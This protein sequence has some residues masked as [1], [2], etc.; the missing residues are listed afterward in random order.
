MAIEI[1]MPKLGLTME[2]ALIIQWLVDDDATVEADQPILLIETDKTETEVGAPGSG[3]LHQIGEPG[4]VFPCG[5][6]IGLL[7][8]E[9][10]T[11]PEPAPTAAPAPVVSTAAV[12][13]ARRRPDSGCGD[14]A[15]DPGGRTALRLTERA[16]D[17]RRPRGGAAHRAR[18]GA[19]RSHRLRRR[20]CGP[21][22]HCPGRAGGQR[23]RGRIGRRAHARRPARHRSRDRAR[24]PGGA[25]RHPGRGRDARSPA[26]RPARATDG[27]RGERDRRR[28]RPPRRQNRR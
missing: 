23:V 6:L 7:L 11:P 13:P 8:A 20:R 10:E 26:P 24:R 19:R 3:R 17:R 27:P 22:R 28:R 9:G 16:A 2:E 1:P 15:G 14:R 25:P 18:H 21:G 4:D 5:Q 12:A